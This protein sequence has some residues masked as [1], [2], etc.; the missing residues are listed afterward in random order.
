[1]AMADNVF[2]IELMV[3]RGQRNYTPLDEHDVYQVLEEMMKLDP[4]EDLE[5][6]Q[7]HS[8][9]LRRVDVCTK[10]LAV[11]E[12]KDLYDFMD[13]QYELDN[14]KV[15][16]ISRPYEEYKF[17]RVK[18]MPVLWTEDTVKRI[19]SFYGVVKS[20]RKETF[21]GARNNY[22]KL[23]NGNWALKMKLSKSIPST[24]SVQGSRFEVW[25]HGQ[26]P[27]CWNCGMAHRKSQCETDK[28][29][30][31][32]KF[33]WSQFP[34]LPTPRLIEASD[35]TSGSSD[36]TA[37]PVVT[38]A[39]DLVSTPVTSDETTASNTAAD[40]SITSET[41]IEDIDMQESSEIVNSVQSTNIAVSLDSVSESASVSEPAS[42]I[43]SGLNS[44]TSENSVTS[45]EAVKGPIMSTVRILRPKSDEET[46][47]GCGTIEKA[48]KNVAIHPDVENGDTSDGF[49][50]VDKAYN[51][52]VVSEIDVHHADG[53]QVT[54]CINASSVENENWKE[55]L[56]AS[57]EDMD[58]V[59]PGQK[60]MEQISI[61]ASQEPTDEVMLTITDDGQ[62][63]D[64]KRK[65]DVIASSEEENSVNDIFMSIGSFVNSFN[66]LGSNDRKE[67]KKLK[68]EDV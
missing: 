15:V 63:E 13:K 22:N 7:M 2:G 25:Y 37:T 64:S 11:W 23:T 9:N 59:T 49:G 46:T 6:I 60:I 4:E 33:S 34:E 21:M 38:S 39:S 42:E 32:N 62:K 51:E 35:D 26:E 61:S 57:E 14:G 48:F 20:L 36:P 56:N 1:M 52:L 3:P 68:K 5:T 58:V 8:P 44:K 10:C 54:G 41:L 40:E 27:T 31:V 66:P 65:K 29:D 12:E 53:S 17:V 28:E 24:L 45:V 18:R 55:T 50:T 19:M 16:L 30:Y 47:D 67:T 43:A